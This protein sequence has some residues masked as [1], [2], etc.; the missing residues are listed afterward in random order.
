MEGRQEEPG[1]EGKGGKEKKGLFLVSAG[2][3]GPEIKAGRTQNS[4]SDRSC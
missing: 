2:V 1:N 4:E 3:G